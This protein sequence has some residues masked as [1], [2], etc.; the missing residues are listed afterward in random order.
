[1]DLRHKLGIVNIQEIGG[2]LTIIEVANPLSFP[3]IMIKRESGLY[4]TKLVSGDVILRFKDQPVGNPEENLENIS[5]DQVIEQITGLDPGS[6][7]EMRILRTQSGLEY[8]LVVTIDP[9]IIRFSLG[10]DDS[11]DLN[12]ACIW[13]GE[14][15]VPRAYYLIEKNKEVLESLVQQLEEKVRLIQDLP[16]RL[17]KADYNINR[18]QIKYLILAQE[19][20]KKKSHFLFNLDQYIPSQRIV[21]DIEVERYN[22]CLVALRQLEGIRDQGLREGRILELLRILE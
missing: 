6:A 12:Q 8:N 20:R 11:Y 15:F 18:A 7:F 17:K 9:S 19:E 13:N 3:S 5:A 16:F 10:E 22:P 4:P 1:M 14:R 21:E 2:R